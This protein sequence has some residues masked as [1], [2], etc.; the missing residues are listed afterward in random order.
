MKQMN[1]LK[2]ESKTEDK[3]AGCNTALR[4]ASKKIGEK[5]KSSYR[6]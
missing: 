5:K 3:N 1:N 4:E 2:T 6:Y